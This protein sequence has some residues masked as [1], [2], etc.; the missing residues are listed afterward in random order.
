M[1]GRAGF[2]LLEVLAALAV[3]GLLTLMLT[4]G[5]RFGW[6]A[7]AR[8]DRV[9][10]DTAELE[11]ADR[12]IRRLIEQSD[13]GTED[14]PAGFQGTLAS[15]GLRTELPLA[16]GSEAGRRIVAAL[17]VDADR[18][19]V[20]RWV[21]YLH[22]QRIG[23]APPGRTATLVHG[24]ARLD[25][26]YWVRPKPAAPGGWVTAL[27]AREPPSL[28]RLRLVFPDGSRRS[29][30]EIAAAPLKERPLE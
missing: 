1:R 18:N 21:P 22:A 5:L 7:S 14:N 24:V 11:A 23:D 6:L 17:G 13:P 25:I 30:P 29:W 26:R 2:T 28:I 9:T 20:L 12:L 10:A 3:F 27:T 16:A 8:Q 19:L 15:M 4:Q